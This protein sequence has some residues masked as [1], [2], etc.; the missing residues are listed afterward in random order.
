MSAS[1]R[2]QPCLLTQ[3]SVCINPY[4]RNVQ[5][6]S[7]LTRWM[8]ECKVRAEVLCPMRTWLQPARR[9]L[10]S[11]HKIKCDPVLE[12][13]SKTA[14]FSVR[15]TTVDLEV[16]SEGCNNILPQ[17]VN[18]AGNKGALHVFS[19]LTFLSIEI[20]PSTIPTMVSSI[21]FAI[22]LLQRG[23]ARLLPKNGVEP[24]SME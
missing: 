3:T 7:Y 8:S 4:S 17:T 11:Q 10:Y 21:C 16:I 14:E 12:R 23:A 9:R 19:N 1:G 22:P 5:R 13:V 2:L 24:T 6:S 18:T 20:S 15:K